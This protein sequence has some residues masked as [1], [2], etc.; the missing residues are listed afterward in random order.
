[1]SIRA[2][3]HRK[4]QNDLQGDAI[5]ALKI[6]APEE[7]NI[8]STP[9]FKALSKNVTSA[10]PE[11]LRDYFLWHLITDRAAYLSEDFVNQNFDFWGK[12]FQGKQ[13]LDERWKRT[14]DVVSGSLDEALGQLYVEKYFPPEA[15]TRMEEL[16]KKFKK[17]DERQH[18]NPS[19]SC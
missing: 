17:P 8:T 14:L 19:G 9:F 13:K 16:I 18:H 1:M 6:P 12:T 3:R 2:W 11:V 4:P 5:A 15:K 10:K 7:I